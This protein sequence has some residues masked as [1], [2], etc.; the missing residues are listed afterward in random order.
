VTMS[1]TERGPAA[2]AAAVLI[3]SVSW[4]APATPQLTVTVQAPRRDDDQHIIEGAD[5]AALPA[6]QA[7]E[8]APPPVNVTITPEAGQFA[9]TGEAAG[10]SP[11]PGVS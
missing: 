4:Q 3:G 8:Q 7:T 6:P 9:F 10:L 1:S 5:T 11:S 2:I